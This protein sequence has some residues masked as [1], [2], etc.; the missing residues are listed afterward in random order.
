MPQTADV[1]SG[2]IDTRLLSEI[3]ERE[4]DSL[5]YSCGPAVTVW[6]RRACAAAG[7]TPPPRFIESMLGHL[8]SLGIPRTRITVES[9][10]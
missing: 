7:T 2:R 3:L 9:Y 4:P 1:R 6:E 5:I 10:G 8:A